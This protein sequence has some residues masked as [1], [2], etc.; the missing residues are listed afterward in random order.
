MLYLNV[1]VYPFRS[2]STKDKARISLCRRVKHEPYKK[3]TH[4]SNL[5]P[6]GM[7]SGALPLSHCSFSLKLRPSLNLNDMLNNFKSKRRKRTSMIRPRYL[8]V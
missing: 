7:E 1:L 5:A 4:D 3:N 8:S 6:F 2:Q